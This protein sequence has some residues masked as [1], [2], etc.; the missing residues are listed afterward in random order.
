MVIWTERKILTM[1][2]RAH[3]LRVE[4]ITIIETTYSQISLGGG[5]AENRLRMASKRNK[6][7]NR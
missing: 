7:I 6:L 1:N 3:L 5:K 4:N 2:M